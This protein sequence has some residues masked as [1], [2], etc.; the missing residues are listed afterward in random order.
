MELWLRLHS[1]TTQNYTKQQVLGKAN[2]T[3]HFHTAHLNTSQQ[4]LESGSGPGG[5]SFIPKYR[6]HSPRQY[7]KSALPSPFH[8]A[9]ENAR[10]LL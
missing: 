9:Q 3:K 10:R 4:G 2:N 7:L 8:G 6:D 5:R 1:E